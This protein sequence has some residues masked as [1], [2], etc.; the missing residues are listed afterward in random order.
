MSIVFYVSFFKKLNTMATTQEKP[1]CLLLIT[2]TVTAQTYAEQIAR[3]KFNISFIGIGK[4][5][6]TARI[7]CRSVEGLLTKRREYPNAPYIL[8]TTR[9]AELS[10]NKPLMEKIVNMLAETPSE[11]RKVLPRTRPN[12]G[13]VKYPKRDAREREI[14]YILRHFIEPS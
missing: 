5:E 6:T 1:P 12:D 8:D 2:D 7:V 14:I 4:P 9:L 3:E 13:P 10:P 11:K